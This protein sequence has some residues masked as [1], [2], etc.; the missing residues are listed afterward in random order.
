[1]IAKTEP[2]SQKRQGTGMAAHAGTQR[3]LP[4]TQKPLNGYATSDTRFYFQVNAN[5]ANAK[6][7]QAT[8]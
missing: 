7:P 6:S 1:L 5:H 3:T 4:K 2:V 8:K